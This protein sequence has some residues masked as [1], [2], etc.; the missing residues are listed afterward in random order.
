MVPAPQHQL[1]FHQL[2]LKIS[3][4]T[5]LDPYVYDIWYWTSRCLIL[6]SE[7]VCSATSFIVTNHD[8]PSLDCKVS[9][10][11]K[12]N[13]TSDSALSWPVWTCLCKGYLALVY[14]VLFD[15]STLDENRPFI[16]CSVLD[17]C[18]C[19]FRTGS[20]QVHFNTIICQYSRSKVQNNG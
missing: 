13:R 16:V 8:M 4:N 3:D 9:I 2:L 17:R 19:I 15:F 14:T 10:T 1:V 12:T 11:A 7:L 6:N 18:R 5:A 20:R